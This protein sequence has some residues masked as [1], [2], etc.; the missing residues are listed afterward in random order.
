MTYSSAAHPDDA[1]VCFSHYIQKPP[2]HATVTLRYTSK[3]LAS[4]TKQATA[5]IHSYHQSARHLLPGWVSTPSAAKHVSMLH[6]AHIHGQRVI[7]LP[8]CV[9][10]QH[11][12]VLYTHAQCYPSDAK[13]HVWKTAWLAQVSEIAGSVRHTQPAIVINATKRTASSLCWS[14]SL[15]GINAESN[16]VL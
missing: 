16:Q 14:R 8:E 5:S 7:Y 6:T 4:K 15:N 1:Y 11:K 12:Q 13:Q 10:W 9:Q 3:L 2:L